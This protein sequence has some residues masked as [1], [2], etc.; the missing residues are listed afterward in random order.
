MKRDTFLVSSGQIDFSRWSK[1]RRAHSLSAVGCA[2]RARAPAHS[3]NLITFRPLTHNSQPF[4]GP[5]AAA[6]SAIYF[7][8]RL[9]CRHQWWAKAAAVAAAPASKQLSNFLLR[10][11]RFNSLGRDGPGRPQK[12]EFSLMLNATDEQPDGPANIGALYK[13]AE[14]LLL[15]HL[16]ESLSS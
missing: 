10:R 7:V 4:H 3:I 6:E 11:S 1:E 14:L 15:S 9:N 12:I 5:A 8:V 2:G 16:R 13:I